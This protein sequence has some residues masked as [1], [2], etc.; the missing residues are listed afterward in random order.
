MLRGLLGKV[1]KVA[2]D[3]LLGDDVQRFW[4]HREAAQTAGN[5]LCRFYHSYRCSRILQRNNAGI[6]DSAR[7]QGR[8]TLPHGLFGIL[9]SQGAVIGRNCTVF[10]HVTIGSNTL[11]DSR[12]P[13]SPVLGDNVFIGA[14]AKVIGGIKVGNNVRIGANCVVVDDVPDDCTVVMPK[15][16]IIQHQGQRNNDYVVWEK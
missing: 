6:P 7:I 13:G 1:R 10:H 9:I 11:K 4:Q 12:R 16:R 8:L 2:K 14:G 5:P 3:L 15:P